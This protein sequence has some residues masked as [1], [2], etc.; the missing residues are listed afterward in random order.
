MKRMT[1]KR[2]LHHCLKLIERQLNPGG[3][4]FASIFIND[5]YAQAQQAK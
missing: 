4:E 2:A 3:W 1:L 5:D